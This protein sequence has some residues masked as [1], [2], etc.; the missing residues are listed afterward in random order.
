LDEADNM[1]SVDVPGGEFVAEELIVH[2]IP[3]KDD[4]FTFYPA[5][6]SGTAPSSPARRTVMPT[7][8]NAKADQRDHPEHRK[9]SVPAR[10]PFRPVKRR[11]V[12]PGSEQ[13][14]LVLRW[15]RA[16]EQFIG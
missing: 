9:M 14:A 12:R 15:R 2:V 7:A 1:D 8:P 6:S 16:C 5:S 3:K 13:V 11:Q 10:C 4:E